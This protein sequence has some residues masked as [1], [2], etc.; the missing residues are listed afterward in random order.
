MELEVRRLIM[1]A[2]PK[3]IIHSE[4]WDPW[5]IETFCHQINHELRPGASTA[6]AAAAA[7]AAAPWCLTCLRVS[8]WCL[9][10][11]MIMISLNLKTSSSAA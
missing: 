4:F 6:D 5:S 1:G 2:F 10:A 3:A 7:A 9:S 8:C 11:S